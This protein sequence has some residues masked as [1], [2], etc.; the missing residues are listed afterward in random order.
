VDTYLFDVD[1]TLVD[2]RQPILL[3]LNTAMAENRL[4][5]IDADQ[6]GRH[7]GPPLQLTL[8]TL[9][10]E[11]GEDTALIPKLIKDYRSA[12]RPLSIELAA[13]YPGITELLDSLTGRVRLAVVTSKP[14]AYA[15]P[16]LET[17]GFA[18]L[19]EIIE[20]PELTEIE[21]K[22]V[23]MARA[24]TRLAFTSEIGGLTMIGDRHHD[25]EAGAQH[26]ARTIGVTWGFGTRQ[27]L[28]DAGANHVVDHPNEILRRLT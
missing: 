15:V 26:S 1:G 27:E 19:F 14:L 21:E 4:A 2:S 24:L 25:I 16:I 13:T 28:T 9:L 17:L 6:L 7:V 8:E 18:A 20:G 12:Y 22:P 23:T 3:A 11:R 10:V 5:A